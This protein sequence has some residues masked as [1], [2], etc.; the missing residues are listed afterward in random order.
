[1]RSNSSCVL[2]DYV[3]DGRFRKT[4]AE[5]VLC[6]LVVDVVNTDLGPA[7]SVMPGQFLALAPVGNV[8]Y[9]AAL[10]GA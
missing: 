10:R 1:M 3:A 8:T 7:N 4:Y 9:G 2:L 5:V 6:K